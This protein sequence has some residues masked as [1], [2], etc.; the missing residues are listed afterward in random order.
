[1]T[2]HRPRVSTGFPVY[3][4]EPYL[5]GAIESHLSQTFEDFELVIVDNASTDGTEEICRRFA[6]ADSRIR[7]HRNAENVGVIR[8]HNRSLELTRGEYFRWISADDRYAPTFL[9]RCVE[10]LDA[11]P[12]VVLAFSKVMHIDESS[13]EVGVDERPFHF[14]SPSASVRFK[15]ALDS[16]CIE[17]FGLMRQTA[18]QKIP[19][20]GSYGHYDGVHLARLALLGRFERAPEP[21]VKVRKHADQAHVQRLVDRQAFVRILDPR[22]EGKWL[23]PRWRLTREYADSIRAAPLSLSERVECYTH[24]ARW[25]KYSYPCYRDDVTFNSR[26]ALRTLVSPWSRMRGTRS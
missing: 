12:E 14:D 21:L 16:D 5:T 8:N 10:I 24:L 3:N 18:L 15:A 22:L 11:D 6:R 20:L 17:E 23:F 25:A 2:A 13:R 4:G 7:Y 1:M 9:E 19:L 26:R